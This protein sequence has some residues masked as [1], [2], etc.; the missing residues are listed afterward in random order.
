MSPDIANCLLSGKN[1]TVLDWQHTSHSY[2]RLMA[3][4]VKSLAGRVYC[5]N[6][7]RLNASKGNPWGRQAPGKT[8]L[9]EPISGVGCAIFTWPSPPAVVLGWPFPW[10]PSGHGLTWQWLVAVVDP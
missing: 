4:P 9:L 2:E 7:R 5:P 1:K 6:D 3:F 10:A 8:S